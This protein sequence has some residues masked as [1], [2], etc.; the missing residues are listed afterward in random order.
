MHKF[1]DVTKT[2]VAFAPYSRTSGNSTGE[3]FS[4]KNYR[5]ACFVIIIA[6]IAAS[7]TV[8]AQ[9]MQ[10]VN[11]A[12]G[13]AKAITLSTCTIT[14]N[15]K[16]QAVTL[17][18]TSAAAADVVTINGLVFT[19]GTSTVKATRH[20]KADGNDA[21]DC[22]ELTACIND[23]TYGVPGVL[24]V[25]GATTVTLTS[26]EPGDTKITIAAPSGS[27]V[28]STDHAIAFLEIEDTDL[29]VENAFD[30]IALKLTTTST[31]LVGAAL[32]RY[33]ARYSPDQEVAASA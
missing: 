13:S 4:M 24:A 29:D 10:A 11:A 7:F 12:A 27:I 16:G 23:P 21:S 28:P 33:E 17:T 19:G 32:L 15:S 9:A 3:Y 18:L 25:A 5:R 2:D 31:V 26:I 1:T 22:T 8:V 30:H 14:A 20:F 6:A